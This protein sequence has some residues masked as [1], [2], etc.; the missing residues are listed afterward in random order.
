MHTNDMYRRTGAQTKSA[1]GSRGGWRRC[2]PA[3]RLVI[4][5]SPVVLCLQQARETWD[6]G[7]RRP[8]LPSCPPT[9]ISPVCVF[10]KRLIR[11]LRCGWVVAGDGIEFAMPYMMHFDACLG[12]CL[13]MPRPM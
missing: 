12:L 13:Q 11:S 8:S 3:M 4:E 7:V 1:T 2:G 9:A 6:R 5:Q 10:N